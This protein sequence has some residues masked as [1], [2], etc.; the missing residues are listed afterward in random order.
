MS[1]IKFQYISTSNNETEAFQCMRKK[2]ILEASSFTD[3]FFLTHIFD[4]LAKAYDSF[5]LSI[6][7][8]LRSK[9][10]EEIT[11]RIRR[12]LQCD[13][14]FILEGFKVNSEPRNQDIAIGYYDLKFEH[15][16]WLNEY[17]V[18]ECKPINTTKSKIDAY[19]HKK[20]KSGDDGGIYRFLI[21]KYATNKS[22]GGMLGY[23]ISDKPEDVLTKLKV[24]ISSLKISTSNLIFGTLED[25]QLLEQPISQFKY[26]FQSKHTR[27]YQNHL[28]TPIHIFHLFMDFT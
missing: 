28:I 22:F 8:G 19:I 5:S 6:K 2:H 20:I 1:D 9:K 4:Y 17:F 7:V 12:S 15:S 25:E 10:E 23:I 21:N 16:D 14:D 26:S 3:N 13:E 18:L 24:N 11:D 27:I